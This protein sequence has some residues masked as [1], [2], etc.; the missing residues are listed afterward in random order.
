MLMG[1]FIGLW[2]IEPISAYDHE[3]KCKTVGMVTTGFLSSLIII[4]LVI[5]LLIINLL[6]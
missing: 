1:V 6:N 4:N 2:A 3:N 5:Y